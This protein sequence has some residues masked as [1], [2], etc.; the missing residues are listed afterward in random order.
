[1]TNGQLTTMLLMFFLL[2]V[3]LPIGFGIML[4][5]ASLAVD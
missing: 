2:V 1:M 3:G 4:L 5:L